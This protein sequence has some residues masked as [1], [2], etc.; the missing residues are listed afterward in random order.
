MTDDAAPDVFALIE[1]TREEPVGHL[2]GHLTERDRADLELLH[3]AGSP[4]HARPSRRSADAL[5]R[6]LAF[7]ALVAFVVMLVIVVTAIAAAAA[8]GRPA[9]ISD[10][11]D[12]LWRLIIAICVLCVGWE[13][14]A[15]IRDEIRRHRDG[16]PGGSP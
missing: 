5:G 13:A 4:Q 9:T 11:L 6:V 7:L 14:V 8:D 3:A 16:P 10:G 2:E 15:W 12:P 1:S